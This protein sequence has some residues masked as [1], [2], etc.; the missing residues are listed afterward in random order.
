MDNKQDLN[1][2]IFGSLVMLYTSNQQGGL[3]C[4]SFLA[5]NNLLRDGF[6]KCIQVVTLE[7]GLGGA[8][9]KKRFLILLVFLMST[10]VKKFH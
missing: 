9:G 1:W 7:N 10:D 4:P 2:P 8:G 5:K 6:H 3:F